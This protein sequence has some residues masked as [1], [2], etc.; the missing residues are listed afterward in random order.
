MLH[1]EDDTA[2]KNN[3]PILGRV[4]FLPLLPT[5]CNFDANADAHP[6]VADEEWT[7]SENATRH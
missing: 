3:V 5:Y 7:T 1:T 2:K 6:P 4:A